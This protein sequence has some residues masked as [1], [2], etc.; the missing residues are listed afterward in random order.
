MKDFSSSNDALLIAWT[1]F[2]E[3]CE[4]L[5]KPI[6]SQLHCDYTI[7]LDKFLFDDAFK[8]NF[9]AL[10]T[11]LFDVPKFRNNVWLIHYKIRDK[12]RTKILLHGAEK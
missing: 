3:I 11:F 8:I 6:I 7:V 4:T 2:L 12:S 1:P 10:P 9:F 5:N